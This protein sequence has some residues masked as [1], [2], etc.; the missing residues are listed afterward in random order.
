MRQNAVAIIRDESEQPLDV[1]SAAA[2]PGL[3]TTCASGT[4]RDESDIDPVGKLRGFRSRGPVDV[5]PLWMVFRFVA[6][7]PQTG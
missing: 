4:L 1:D 3:T 6:R 7:S 5:S 2:R